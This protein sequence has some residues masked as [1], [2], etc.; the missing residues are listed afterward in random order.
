MSGEIIN[1]I[2]TCNMDKKLHQKLIKLFFYK[3]ILCCPEV[4]QTKL[5]VKYEI[6]LCNG[7]Q[8]YSNVKSNA[9]LLK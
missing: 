8:K 6:D 4:E 2:D 5:S 1:F 9:Q 7:M 3:P